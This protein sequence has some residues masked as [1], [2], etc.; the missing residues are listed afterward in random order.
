MFLCVN[1]SSKHHFN[2]SYFVFV[3]FN[4]FFSFASK[5]EVFLCAPEKM[6]VTGISFIYH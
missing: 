3:L 5:K 2:Y 1:G 4:R 6:Y